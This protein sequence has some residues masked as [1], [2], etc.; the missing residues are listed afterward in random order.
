MNLKLVS[1]CIP[2][3]NGEKYLQEALDSVKKQTYSNIEVIISD[4]HSKDKT[5]EIC[6]KFKSEADFPVYIYSHQPQGIGANW[7]YC[8]NQSNG[9]FIKFLFQDDI[10]EE[11]CIQEFIRLQQTTNEEVFFCKRRLID[12]NGNDLEKEKLEKIPKVIDLQWVINLEIDRYHVFTKK[13]LKKIGSKYPDEISHNFLGEPVASFA[14]KKSYIKT[15][16]HNN[17]LKQLLDL[18]YS[19]RVLENYNIV[20]TSEKLIRFRIHDEQTTKINQINQVNEFE[21]ISDLIVKKYF[22]Y[23]HRKVLLKYYYKKYPIIG[24]IRA[25]LPF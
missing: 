24:K 17:N 21:Y 19:L 3:Y 18:E 5:L 10:L 1:I 22:K 16:K 11:N 13:D 8:I 14:S 12:K 20:I 6:E 23:L 2:T 25:L 4:D 15:G 7:D 9:E